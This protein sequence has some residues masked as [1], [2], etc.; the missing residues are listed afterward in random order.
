[1]RI[2]F[3]GTSTFGLPSLEALRRSSH[4]IL[5]IVT[6]LD[7]PKGRHLKLKASPI[8]HW[9]QLHD[10]PY[11]E[12]SKKSILQ[13]SSMIRNFDAD[14]LVVISF[15]LILP[16]DLIESPKLMT[17]NVHSSLLPKYRGAAPIHW[18]LM[19]GDTE[20]GVTIM[21]MVE[22]L[23]AGDILLQKKTTIETEEDIL[24][25]DSRLSQLGADALL[26]AI[27]RLEHGT[28]TFTS[29][30]ETQ[31][32]TAR[33]ISKEDGHIEWNQPALQ[34]VHWIRALK[35][36][37]KSFN[38]YGGKRILVLDAEVTSEEN[39]NRFSPGTITH[40]SQGVGIEVAAADRLVRIK[41]LQLEGKKPLSASEFLKGFAMSP[42]QFL[43]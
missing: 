33:K 11:V 32:T 3:F 23:D 28:L 36:W 34:I 20:T 39:K 12:V 22:K 40:L 41:T 43:E 6:T 13:L 30:D 42:G 2:V 26:E 27:Q 4:Q 14:L 29:Q 24:S 7:K 10:F 37:P 5:S 25:L 35:N 31:S 21:R 1:M 17:I 38:F 15:G 16:K 18:A 9:A 8:K 19:N